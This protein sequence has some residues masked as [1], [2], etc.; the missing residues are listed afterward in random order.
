[1]TG[2]GRSSEPEWKRRRRLEQV[3]GDALP[4]TTSAE[5]EPETAPEGEDPG[6][7]GLREQVPPHHG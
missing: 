5:G 2:S 4:D 3:F 1:M 6:E 7:R